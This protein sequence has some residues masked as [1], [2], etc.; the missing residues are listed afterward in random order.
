MDIDKELNELFSDPLLDVSDKELTLFNMPADMKRVL[1]GR[2]L[3]PDHYAKKKQ[4]VDFHLYKP[5]FE[6]VQK[7][8]KE[9]RRNLIR[10]SKTSNLDEGHFYVVDG[11]LILLLSIEETSRSRSGMIDGRTRCIYENGT[12]S[13]IL[14]ETLRRNVLHE[15]FGVTEPQ[16]S[17][18]DAFFNQKMTDGDKSTGYVY[19]LRSLSSDPEIAQEKN[20]YKIGFTINTV[21][22][23]IA[24]AEK[25][26]TYLM[27]PVQIV[28]TAQ[29]VNMNSHI[30][31]TLMHQVFDSVQFQ[32]KVYDDDGKLHIPTE[33]YVVPLDIINLV[34]QKITDGSITQYSYNPQLQCLEK[35]IAKKQSTFNTEGLKVLTL[36]IRD[37]YF[38]EILKGEKTI[39]YREIKQ[40]TINKYTYIDEADGKR[41]LRRYDVIRFFV[42]YHKDRESALV[43]VLNT[44]YNEGIVE[45]HLGPV[46]E[47]IK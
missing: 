16:D 21:E 26:P 9:G 10:T 6:K 17:I 4:C 1:E 45:Y 39:E 24:N 12:E 38:Q 41:Y 34:I 32:L 15:G 7:D 2:R 8:L 33:W 36:N 5:L 19:V 47:H 13:D 37:Q 29:I 20:L 22:E 42:G 30:F 28:E 27:A 23:R 25:E 35:R 18:N 14:L 44:T 46:L 40:T 43:Q 11:M 31:E 3:Q